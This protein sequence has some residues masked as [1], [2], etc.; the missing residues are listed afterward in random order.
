MGRGDRGRHVQGRARHSG[1]GPWTQIGQ[2]TATWFTDGTLAAGTTYWYRVRG[3]T[4]AADG[5]YSA[6][7]SQATAPTPSGVATWAGTYTTGGTTLN[8]SS[9][10]GDPPGGDHPKMTNCSLC[11]FNYGDKPA[12]AG[13]QVVDSARHIDGSVDVDADCVTC[14]SYPMG[15]RREMVSEFAQTWS[16]K[17]SASGAVTK[18]D[19]VV[20]HMEGNPSDG[21]RSAVH[22]D[23]VV[24]LRDPD[25][26]NNIET[27]TFTGAIGSSGSAGSYASNS[28]TTQTF[29]Q[30]RRN[31]GV[32]L[33]ADNA[34]DRAAVQA[35]M[36]NQCLK[37]HDADG[38]QAFAAGKPLNV[39]ITSNS[40]PGASAGRPFGQSIAGAGYN[41]GTTDGGSSNTACTTAGDN[42]CVA[43]VKDSFA[44]TN[45]SY[46]PVLGRNNNWYA[47]ASRMATPWNLAKIN[48]TTAN[49]TEY[50]YLMSCWDCHADPADT[51][52][53]TRTVTAHGGAATVRGNPTV[54]NTAAAPALNTNE[55]SLCKVC[56]A[57]YQTGSST[58]GSG[59]AL[60]GNTNNG[61]TAYLNY[62]C[63]VCHSSNF[64]T[65]VVRPLRGKDVHGVNALPTAG[66]AKQGR[67]S[68]N[69]RPY[70]FIRNTAT[71]QNHAPL[72]ISG[73]GYSPTCTM[74]TDTPSGASC[75]Q[76]ARG[77]TVGGTY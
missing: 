43:N 71:L 58:H 36:F 73:T 31:L 27:V 41:G 5:P 66:L 68:T 48:T 44:T 2:T 72:N 22:G 6:I 8:C 10:H 19:C 21:G 76:G 62:G 69:P 26:G 33:E 18:W 24:N 40:I 37:C 15:S 53:I 47:R 25:T 17:K 13:T 9:C 60:S 42:G 38:A 63:N 64:N 29:T 56:H 11:H 55:A 20:C 51:G 74:T 14:H 34:T 70:A 1:T 61:M 75:N 67:W 45:S 30:F 65:A 57:G 23:G 49:A 32:T 52:T 46:H 3:S 4:T 50:G 39:L 59:S 77:Y 35:M 7:V 12:G 28:G 16:H 54:P